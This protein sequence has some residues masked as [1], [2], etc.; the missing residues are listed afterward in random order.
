MY[1]I[2]LQCTRIDCQRAAPK[3]T[4][5][6]RQ[7]TR[8]SSVVRSTPSDT[9]TTLANPRSEPICRKTAVLSKS[10]TE[11]SASARFAA[12]LGTSLAVSALDC[13]S[14][15]A[16]STAL[17]SA[18]AT[19]LGGLLVLGE[20]DPATAAKLAT[21]LRPILSLGS[22]LMIVRIVMS[23]FPEVK[24]QEMPWALAYYPT[25]PVLGP[26]RKIITP[27]NGVDISPIVSFAVI[28]FF[29]EI[30]LGPQ[31][32]LILLSQKIG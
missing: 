15:M 21:F 22:V 26:L 29:N 24:D 28:S 10:S 7:S 32:L 9:T 13:D 19:T 1:S 4:C 6:S 31:G 14:A 25:E 8:P 2:G 18:L 12:V 20:I 17:D 11:V 16:A 5:A 27:V 30:L 23:W 3:R